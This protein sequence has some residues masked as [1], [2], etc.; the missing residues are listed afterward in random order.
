MVFS[1][2]LFSWF[3]LIPAIVAFGEKS[4]L[5]PA[6]VSIEELYASG[7]ASA[8]WSNY[9]RYIGAGALA[10]A[11]IISLIKSLPLIISTFS[12]AVR[13]LKYRNPSTTERT[14]KD[15]S[16]TTVFCVLAAI[17]LIMALVP[18]IP[19]GIFGAL[20]ILILGFFFSTVA[21]KLAGLVGSSNSPISGMTIATLLFTSVIFKILGKTD[22][23]D[24][25]SIITI[26]AVI[27][28]ICAVSNDMSQDLKAGFILGATLHSQQ[29]GEIIGV[30]ISSIAVGGIL[31]LLNKAWGFGSAELAAPQATLMKLVI[32]GV[33]NGNL[34]WNYIF[35]GVA[36]SVIFEIMRL[37]ALTIAIGM[38][39]PMESTTFLMVVGILSKIIEKKNGYSENSSGVLFCFGLVAGEGL[40]GIL[41]ALFAVLKI[42][43]NRGFS[44]GAPG[45]ILTAVIMVLAVFKFGIA[46]KNEEPGR[47]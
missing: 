39:L 21:A 45:C 23:A 1:G 25:V 42:N 36:F 16:M 18:V 9:I 43:L 44:L 29:I 3:V 24:W 4:V 26:G 31:T 7:G 35:I 27:C 37:H 33:V 38:Y 15:M 11:G 32:E 6:R 8:I 2:G 19:V 12:S 28:T 40:I 14:S 22:A 41:L 13:D 46:K 10:A 5:Y 34:P 20:L 17:V 30:V 47:E